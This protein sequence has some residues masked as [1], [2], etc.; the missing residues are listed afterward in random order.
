MTNVHANDAIHSSIG[1]VVLDSQT[2][3][4]VDNGNVADGSKSCWIE[5]INPATESGN[6]SHLIGLVF[7]VAHRGWFERKIDDQWSGTFQSVHQLSDVRHTARADI[8]QTILEEVESGSGESWYIVTL[9]VTGKELTGIIGKTVEQLVHRI[10][11]HVIG[12]AEALVTRGIVHGEYVNAIIVQWFEKCISY[13]RKNYIRSLYMA[14][15]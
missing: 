13:V 1:K 11:G 12:I 10:I 2:Q 14:E 15:K 5:K 6:D 8:W 9:R 3:G 4:C 7:I